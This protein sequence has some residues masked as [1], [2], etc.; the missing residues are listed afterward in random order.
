MFYRCLTNTA[1]THTHTHMRKTNKI[2]TFLNNSFHLIYPR[3]VPN[4][5]LFII[6]SSV[7]AAMQYLTMHLRR[8]L[9]ADAIRH[10]AHTFQNCLV[11]HMLHPTP[12]P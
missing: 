4:K 12:Y 9:V 11:C 10:T 8:S 2:H 7:Q 3:H 5:Q 6:R 1:H